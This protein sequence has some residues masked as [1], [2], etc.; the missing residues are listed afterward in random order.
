[1]SV[2]GEYYVRITVLKL[3]K[4]RAVRLGA[5]AAVLTALVAGTAAYAAH[6][7]TVQLTVDGKEQDVRVFGRTVDDVLKA[8]DVDVNKR[9][10]V[11]PALGERIS[12]GS[13]VVVR[14][15]RL[16]TVTVDGETQ[17]HWTTA[18]T[19]DE[20][21]D[22]LNV[23]ADGARLSASRSTPLGRKGLNLEVVTPKDVTIVADGKN[24][25]VTSTAPTVGAL[26]EENGLKKATADR[27][28][29]P[30]ANPLTDGL[31]IKLVRVTS[32]QVT[33]TQAIPFETKKVE[34]ND[35]F[36]GDTKV[37]EDGVA[38]VRTITYT[39]TLADGVEEKRVKSGEQVTKQPVAKV[40]EV[41]TKERPAP[42]TSSS[43]S[44]PRVASG[45]DWDRLAQCESG[46]NWQINSGNGYYGGLQ[47][48]ASSWR[49]VG[50]SGLPHQHSREVQI[51]MGE[52]L[53]AEQ[54]WGAWPACSAKLGLR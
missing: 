37:Q 8:A 42:K 27:V 1:M 52:R 2:P 49:A 33:E 47:F 19:V 34:S 3:P 39:V 54:G 45:S 7:T 17:Q 44:A 5:Q 10:V 30:L 4:S 21:L 28:S 40:V 53:K 50:G 23:R 20:A 22:D 25:P 14:H 15:A 16:L 35:L 38:G 13:D 48:S 32:K 46:G 29:A 11:A 51:Q 12:E 26:L 24:R 6:D 9:D 31:V 36:K 41:G 18:L 43:S